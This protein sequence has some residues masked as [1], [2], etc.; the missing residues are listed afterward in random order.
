VQLGEG[1]VLLD[2][3]DRKFAGCAGKRGV[4]ILIFKLL[5]KKHYLLFSSKK[6]IKHFENAFI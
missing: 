5:S 6:M 2:I 1:V 4:E 3:W